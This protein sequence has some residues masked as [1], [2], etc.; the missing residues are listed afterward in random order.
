MES[1]QEQQQDKTPELAPFV[2]PWDGHAA[3]DPGPGTV[4]TVPRHLPHLFSPLKIRDVTFKNRV[5]VSPMCTYSAVDGLMNDWHLVHLGTFAK[6]GV[7]L[8]F[9]EAAGVQD[10]G[11]ITPWDAGIWKDE[12][13]AP[14]KRIVDFVHSQNALAGMQ[15]AHAGR[16]ASTYPPHLTFPH[17]SAAVPKEKGGWTPTAPSAV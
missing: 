7:G 17:P 4:R 10:V 13:I 12:H 8:I 2:A 9:C 1:K 16:K 14:L 5:V 3:A 15:L 11:R 6:G